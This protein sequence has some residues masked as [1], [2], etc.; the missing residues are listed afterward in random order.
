MEM[1]PV[2]LLLENRPMEYMFNLAINY[3][4]IHLFRALFSLSTSHPLDKPFTAAAVQ[5]NS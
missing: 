4:V 3:L 2:N 5:H 1:T